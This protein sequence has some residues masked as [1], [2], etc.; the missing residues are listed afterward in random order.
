M[1][2]I[3]VANREARA[4]WILAYVGGNALR[5]S[6]EVPQPYDRH[7]QGTYWHMRV[8]TL[9]QGH[10]RARTRSR[11]DTL[12]LATDTL[13]HI[14]RRGCTNEATQHGVEAAQMRLRN[15]PGPCLYTGPAH[16]RDQIQLS[17]NPLP[18]LCSH[19]LCSHIVTRKQLSRN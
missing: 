14:R 13:A 19:P 11:T 7:T 2:Q 9:A 15:W 8:D 16:S 5:H 12:A 4:R 18:G 6:R 3:A 1:R 10:A 17:R